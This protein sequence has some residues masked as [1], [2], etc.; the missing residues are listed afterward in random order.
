MVKNLLL[1]VENTCANNLNIK[2]GR[3]YKLAPIIKRRV[4]IYLTRKKTVTLKDDLTYVTNID[5]LIEGFIIRLIKKKFPQDRIVCEETKNKESKTKSIY[6][7]VI[8]PIDGTQNFIEGKP[9][10]SVSIGLMKGNEFHES[11]VIFPSLGE[12]LYAVKNGGTKL[13]N[14]VVHLKKLNVK[15]QVILCSKTHLKYIHFLREKG[16][17]TQFFRCATYSMLMV[18]KGKAILYHTI[19]TMLYDVGPMS[20]ILSEAGAVNHIGRFQSMKFASTDLKVPFFL[21]VNPKYSKLNLLTK[22]FKRRSPFN[23]I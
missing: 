8:D 9:E 15:R 18:L 22:I 5:M 1:M 12:S 6:T 4:L 17:N 10:Y 21:T 23:P 19:N 13:N 7:W 14:E 20:L 11:L 16:Y 3:L 2:Y